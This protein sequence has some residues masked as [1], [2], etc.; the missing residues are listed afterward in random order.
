MSAERGHPVF[1]WVYARAARAT[2]AGPLGR[3]RAA[4]VAQARGV[5]LDLGAG[6]GLN[7]GHL[8]AAVTGLHLVEP[9]PHMRARLERVAPP[10]AAVH[11]AG[12][13]D[14]PVPD[15]SVDTA[16]STLTLCSVDDPVAVAHELRRV[17]RPGGRLLLLEHVLS[18]DPRVARR[19]R[20]LTPL[21]RRFAGGCHL[22][23]D[24]G[25]V[26]AEAGFETSGLE[27]VEVPVPAVTRE[28]LVGAA[29]VR[30]APRPGPVR[31][32]TPD[33]RDRS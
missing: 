13:E 4:L 2:D 25:R 1:A 16:L 11:A 17:L 20:R 27:R 23:R 10:S 7:L 19:Q 24:T 29:V 21:Q 8:P 18:E 12:G 33:V 26:F 28:L 31:S 30:R 32:R 14:L 15:A 5:T 3:H 22:D 9:D 6:T